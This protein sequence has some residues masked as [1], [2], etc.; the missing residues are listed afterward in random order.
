MSKEGLITILLVLGMG[1]GLYYFKVAKKAPKILISE[2]TMKS[3]EG[4]KKNIYIVGNLNNYTVEIVTSVENNESI[5]LE[6]KRVIT[7]KR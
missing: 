1:V 2:G 3:K 7:L 5:M 6:P 4:K